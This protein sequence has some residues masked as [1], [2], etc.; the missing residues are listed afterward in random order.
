MSAPLWAPPAEGTLSSGLRPRIERDRAA[1]YG[2][3]HWSS[4]DCR[5]AD[6]ERNGLRHGEMAP[7]GKLIVVPGMEG[8]GL[9]HNDRSGSCGAVHRHHAITSATDAV[10][11]LEA[12]QG[13]VGWSTT[14]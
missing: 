12:P 1:P 6:A 4:R 11:R 8:R 10:P 13:E 5:E 9:L 2:L 7:L 14:T 3:R